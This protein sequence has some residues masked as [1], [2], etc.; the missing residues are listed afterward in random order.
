[1]LRAFRRD[2]VLS[3]RAIDIG[4]IGE[5]II[6]LS[7]WVET[8]EESEHAMAVT[9][10]VPGIVTVVS[11]LFIGAD[12]QNASDLDED[13]LDDSAP[14]PG[15]VWEGQRVGTG[16]RRQGNSGEIDRHSDPKPVLEGKWLD[17]DHALDEAAG[18]IEGLAERRG[19]KGKKADKPASTNGDDS[20]VP[21]PS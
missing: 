7:G 3:E 16:R 15:G 5:G 20:G 9:R 12:E 11:R 1:V 2:A 4:A 21:S 10:T 18:P 14:I 8:H 6:E 17:E 13:D 19:R